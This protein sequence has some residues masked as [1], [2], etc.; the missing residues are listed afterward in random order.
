MKTIILMS[1]GLVILT[2]VVISQALH[3]ARNQRKEKRSYLYDLSGDKAGERL[4]K[5]D[6]TVSDEYDELMDRLVGLFETEK[7]CLQPDVRITAVASALAVGKGTLSRAIKVKTG[8]NF[9]QLVH[10][11][12]IREAMRIYAN[13]PNLPVREI[14]RKV[15]FN[16]QTTFI[17]AFGRHTGSTP[18]EWCR[19]Y[20]KSNTTYYGRRKSKKG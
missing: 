6:S 3:L 9:C 7:V 18:A 20:K 16:S 5:D 2:G 14:S 10:Y 17:T 12:R 13:H 11:Y 19:Q 8:K 15:G 4:L 1:A